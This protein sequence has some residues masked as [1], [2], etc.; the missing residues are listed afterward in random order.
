MTP[1]LKALIY[2]RVSSTKQEREGS[3]LSSQEK[4]CREYAAFHGYNVEQIFQDTFT[5]GGDF[6]KR[7]AMRKLLE[8]V[9]KN[10]KTTYVVIFDDLKRFARDTVFHIKLRQEFRHRNLIPKCLNFNFEESAEGEFVETIIAAT[11]QLER[12]QNKRQVLQKMKSRLDRGVYCMGGNAPFG[13]V[14]KKNSTYGGKV[15]EI[16]KDE[17]EIT[18]EAFYGFATNKL[19]H[20]KDV[21]HFINTHDLFKNPAPLRA[22]TVRRML[23]NIIYAGYVEYLPWKIIRQKGIHEAI[24][25]LD[26]FESVQERIKGKV[27]QRK[28]VDMREDFPL[29][30]YVNCIHCHKPLTGA[31]S[32]GGTGKKFAYY[33]C[34]SKD[35]HMKYKGIPQDEVHKKFLE[36]LHKIKPDNDIL[37]LVKYWLINEYNKQETLAL[38]QINKKEKEKDLLEV[39]LSALIKKITSSTQSVLSEIFEQEAIKIKNRI[40]VLKEIAIDNEAVSLQELEL[41]IDK[42]FK[43]L[44]NA[45]NTWFYG[46]FE[47]RKSIQNMILSANLEYGKNEKFGT[48]EKCYV[49]RLFQEIETK[50]T[51]NFDD[52]DIAKN[53]WNEL[54]NDIK[55]IA[56]C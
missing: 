15:L 4:R 45:Y 5:G 49:L 11:S 40:E 56:D 7:P 33:R 41:L 31:W 2:C 39:Q 48:P 28:R 17:A 22:E 42:A 19:F 35:C 12:E 53:S 16:V 10:K 38:T 44:E 26:I 18:K 20:I 9:D 23:S 24:I 29:R 52:V 1:N 13:Y 34:K 47:E 14:F 51:S 6:M 46:S 8:Y 3:G 36:V 25:P 54:I 55:R 50:N 37:I 27:P 43:K 32:T 30:G 21:A